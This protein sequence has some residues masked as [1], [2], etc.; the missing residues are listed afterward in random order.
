[1]GYA[2][3]CFLF[4]PKIGTSPYLEIYELEREPYFLISAP[5]LWHA[6]GSPST[7]GSMLHDPTQHDCL[8]ET[9]GRHA[10]VKLD[11]DP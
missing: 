5:E 4:R 8:A 7:H 2:V 6:E 10:V 11:S 3:Q 9:D 1:M